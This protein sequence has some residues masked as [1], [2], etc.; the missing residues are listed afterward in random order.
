MECAT[1]APA[2]LPPWVIACGA[3]VAVGL[4]TFA[5]YKKWFAGAS[6]VPD[7]GT[8][9]APPR[10]SSHRALLV[11]ANLGTVF[12]KPDTVLPQWVEAFT[13][14][15]RAEKVVFVALHIQEV[16]GKDYATSMHLVDGFIK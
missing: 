11:A 1:H 6:S 10:L 5:V 3:A 9:P 2:V 12:E 7:A 8:T 14:A 15:V 4:V 13:A 16:G